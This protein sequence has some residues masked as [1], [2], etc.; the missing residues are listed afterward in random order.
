MCAATSLVVAKY[1]ET[2]QS[3]KSWGGVLSKGVDPN[4]SVTYDKEI[5]TRETIP[6]MTPFRR[7]QA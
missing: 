5:W 7:L 1:H 6:A 2:V 3:G 4:A